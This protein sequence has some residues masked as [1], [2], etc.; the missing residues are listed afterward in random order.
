MTYEESNEVLGIYQASVIMGDKDLSENKMNVCKHPEKEGD[1]S[2]VVKGSPVNRGILKFDQIEKEW[3]ERIQ[4]NIKAQ[5]DYYRALGRD[6]FKNSWL[7]KIDEFEIS[8]RVHEDVVKKQKRNTFCFLNNLLLKQDSKQ[9]SEENN[10]PIK[11]E[12]ITDSEKLGF[13]RSAIRVKYGFILIDENLS[14]FCVYLK[15]LLEGRVVS[16]PLGIMKVVLVENKKYD[17]VVKQKDK[18]YW[19]GFNFSK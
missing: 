5:L 10:E 16:T 11:E 18:W 15:N 17:L 19:T 9:D 6:S 13:F 2:D 7:D 4:E 8:N 12:Y 3:D 1:F 14:E